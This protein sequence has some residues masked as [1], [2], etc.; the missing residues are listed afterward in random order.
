MHVW[1]LMAKADLA[2][3]RV[4]S[5]VIMFLVYPAYQAFKRR[6]DEQ[7]KSPRPASRR[8]P[9]PEADAKRSPPGRPT[10]PPPKA[11][12]L[13]AEI[14]KFL[15]QSNHEKRPLP[16]TQPATTKPVRVEPIVSRRPA[17]GDAVGR[18]LG[19]RH[20]D[21]SEF[22]ARASQ[23]TDDLKRGDAEREQHFQQ[24]FAHKLGRLTDTSVAGAKAIA[25][26]APAVS[27]VPAA[28]E[29]LSDW[30]PLPT[31]TTEDLRRAM[32]LNE[33]LQRPEHRW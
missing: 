2:W 14:Q 9:G 22:G 24:T 10:T 19:G 11:D 16:R 29:P 21:T 4:V 31:A 18:P 27:T 15:K 26:E 6:R 23:M 8:S 30:L 25:P 28:P 33:I 3:L 7:P 17:V 32:M 5:F 1:W 13:L 12:P 20:L